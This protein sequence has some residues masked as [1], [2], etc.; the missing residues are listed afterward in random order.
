MK[1]QLAIAPFLLLA[2]V[3][4]IETEYGGFIHFKK[5][6]TTTSFAVLLLLPRRF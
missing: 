3:K 2:K 1:F 5:M 4:S 6:S